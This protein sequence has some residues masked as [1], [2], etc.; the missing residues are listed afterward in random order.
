MTA[1]DPLPDAHFTVDIVLEDARGKPSGPHWQ[2]PFA[3]V[4]LPR[5]AV[6][7]DPAARLVLRRGASGALDLHQW[8]AAERA[9]PG[10]QPHIVTVQAMR[11]PGAPPAMGWRFD[12]V[13]PVALSYSPLD[14]LSGA[15]LMETIELS[16]ASMDLIGTTTPGP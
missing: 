8:L 12:K 4:L 6:A 5:A 9:S 16:F 3:Q 7:P 15:T 1:P 2:I 11:Q 10:Q 13:H 14:A